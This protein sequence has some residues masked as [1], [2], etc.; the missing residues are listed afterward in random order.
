MYIQPVALS[1]KL[2][3]F[4][5]AYPVQRRGPEMNSGRSLGTKLMSQFITDKQCD[6]SQVPHL[7]EPQCP[8]L[9]SGTHSSDGG[10]DDTFCL[11]A[12]HSLWPKEVFSKCACSAGMGSCVFC[13]SYWLKASYM[14]GPVVDLKCVGWKR[15]ARKGIKVMGNSM[16]F[17]S[18]VKVSD[19]CE[20]CRENV[21]SGE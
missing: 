13:S 15:W 3:A 6:C 11:Q 16:A 20:L 4:L 9:Y 19:A 17:R 7:S 10:K 18:R 5:L 2:S 1:P 12:G 14:L 8:R 21:E